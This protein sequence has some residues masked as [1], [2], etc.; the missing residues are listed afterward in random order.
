MRQ[1]RPWHARRRLAA[2]LLCGVVLCWLAFAV[3]C[4]S[5]TARRETVPLC[6]PWTEDAVEGFGVLL[7]LDDPALAGLVRHIED[8]SHYCREVLPGWRGR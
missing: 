5:G 6:P 1:P 7:G 2:S 4:A 8:V 3:A